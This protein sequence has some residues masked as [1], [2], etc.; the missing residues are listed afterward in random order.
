MSS[1]GESVIYSHTCIKRS[2]LGQRKCPYKT[3]DLK[4]GPIHMKLSERTRKR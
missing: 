3:G 2:P 4:R 1:M